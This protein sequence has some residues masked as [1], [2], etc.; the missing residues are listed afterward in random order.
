MRR[1]TVL[2]SGCLVAGLMTTAAESVSHPLQFNR[3]VVRVATNQSGNWSG[4]NQG[5]L[6]KGTAFHEVSGTWVVPAARQHRQ[7]ENEYS[8]TWVGIGGGC[9]DS[10]CTT[11]D[12]TLIQA[13][14]EQDVN[15]RGVASYSAWWEIIPQPS[16]RVSLSVSAGQRVRVDVAET[17]P[18]VWAISIKNLTTGR[19]FS[20]TTPYSSSYATAE[21]IEETPLIISG[22]SSGVAALPGLGKVVFDGGTAN[23]IN[24]ALKS[25]EEIQLVDGSGHVLATPSAPDSDRNGFGDCTYATSCS[26]PSS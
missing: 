20:T 19:S 11:T 24:P 15:S 4:Y 23:K 16:T 2:V 12:Q 1:T 9:V 8:A 18:Q 25:S 7:G 6:E 5:Q 21:W 13:G 3:T 26:S 14:T 22:G 10:G 17:T